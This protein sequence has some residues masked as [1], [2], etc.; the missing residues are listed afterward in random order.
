MTSYAVIAALAVSAAASPALLGAQP[1]MAREWVRQP[2]KDMVKGCR[3]TVYEEPDFKGARW[4][5][6]NGWEVIG[7]EFNDK[8]RSIKV[9][10]G[11]WQFFRDDHFEHQIETLYPGRYGH[12]MPNSDNVIS[13]FR[14]VRTT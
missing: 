4:S 1:A 3:V 2:V 7:W 13:S 11:I 12:L 9:S 8:I 10:S 6:T 5:T 14:C